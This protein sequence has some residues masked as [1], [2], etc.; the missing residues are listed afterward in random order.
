MPG[1]NPDAFSEVPLVG[2]RGKTRFGLPEL[3]TFRG[4][5]VDEIIARSVSEFLEKST[6]NN[7]GDIKAALEKIG[8][9]PRVADKDARTLGAMMAR[10]HWIA[11]RADRNLRKGPGHHPVTSLAIATVTY[12][13]R[14]VER[15]GNELLSRT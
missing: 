9:N 15:F 13:M 1:A 2:T 7:P 3:A 4:R 5:T 12:W 11:H 10:R 8:I 6:V 14:T